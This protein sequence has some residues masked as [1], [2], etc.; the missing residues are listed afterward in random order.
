M[1]V[2]TLLLGATLD[3]GG[4]VMWL[5]VG[6]VAGFLASR[7]MSGGGLWTDRRYCGGRY[8]RVLGRM[9]EW[10]AGDR[11]VLWTDWQY[12]HC[13]YWSLYSPRHPSRCLWQNTRTARLATG[14]NIG[15]IDG[16]ALKDTPSTR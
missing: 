16:A 10:S 12:C 11:G 1:T 8:W 5:I 3:P 14:M 4:L 13:L 7:V 9:G 6:L 2:A 15:P